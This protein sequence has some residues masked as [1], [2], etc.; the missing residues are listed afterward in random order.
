MNLSI[1]SAE[2]AILNTQLSLLREQQLIALHNAASTVMSARGAAEYDERGHRIAG[3]YQRL[4][5][6]FATPTEPQSTPQST[7][8]RLEQ[9]SFATRLLLNRSLMP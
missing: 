8:G 1:R 5:R 2:I 4:A 9:Q 3:L 6:L 7:C